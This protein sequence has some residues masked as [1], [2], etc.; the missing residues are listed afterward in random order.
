MI[1]ATRLQKPDSRFW[2]VLMFMMS[3]G[4]FL[5]LTEPMPGVLGAHAS[6]D[7][8]NPLRSGWPV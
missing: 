7:S 6:G 2:E 8:G 4:A 1:A 3:A 5:M